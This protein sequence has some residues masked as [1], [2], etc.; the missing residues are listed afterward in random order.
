MSQSAV[1]QPQPDIKYAIRHDCDGKCCGYYLRMD[2]YDRSRPEVITNFTVAPISTCRKFDRQQDA[3]PVVSQLIELYADVAGKNQFTIVERDVSPKLYRVE[4]GV[5]GEDRAYKF[6]IAK[7]FIAEV[8]MPDNA[9]C[10][11]DFRELCLPHWEQSDVAKTFESYEWNKSTFG[12]L[13][14]PGTPWYQK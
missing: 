4:I 2:H 3:I 9:R 5:P 1:E 7:R 14:P 11:D 13:Y 8:W 12:I 10:L 6:T